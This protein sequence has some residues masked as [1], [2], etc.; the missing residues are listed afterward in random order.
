MARP[1]IH[2]IRRES[3]AV[4]PAAVRSAVAATSRRWH[5]DPIPTARSAYRPPSAASSGSSP[6]SAACRE[7]AVSFVHDLDHVGPFARCTADLALAMTCCK[8]TMRGSGLRNARGRA[9]QQRTGSG[10]CPA[11]ALAYWASGFPKARARKHW[12]P[13]NAWPVLSTRPCAWRCPKRG[14]RALRRSASPAPAAPNCIRTACAHRHRTF[15]PRRVIAS[16]PAHYCRPPCW[17]RHSDCAAGLLRVPAP[18]SSAVDILLAPSTPGSPLIGQKTMFLATP[19]YQPDRTSA[20][21]RSRQL[22][23]PARRGGAG[24]DQRRPAHRRAGDCPTL[25]GGAGAARC[26][27]P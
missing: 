21:T 25:A 15:D 6:P 9:C 19:K 4:P 3:L 20:S 11:C 18:C 13:S 27:V 14:A 17:R 10:N 5:W 26:G 2:M 1:A 24:V 22:H 16:L 23:R 8:D 12:M 7:P